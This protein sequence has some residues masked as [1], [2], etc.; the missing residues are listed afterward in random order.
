MQSRDEEDGMTD[1]NRHTRRHERYPFVR[2][3]EYAPTSGEKKTLT[4]YG[5]NLS[6]S[7]ICFASS[8]WIEKG[9][10]I[11]FRTRLPTSHQTGIVM[12]NA[13]IDETLFKAGVMF[14]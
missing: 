12:W 7:G 3:I 6:E 5:V 14:S 4:G 11:R 2:A 13:K 10:E 1:E 8:T 9:Q